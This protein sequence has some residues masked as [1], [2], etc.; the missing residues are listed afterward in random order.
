MCIYHS[1]NLREDALFDTKIPKVEDAGSITG[2]N[3]LYASSATDMTGLTPSIAHNEHEAQ[4]YE[5][6]YPYLPP[7]TD[8]ADGI[9]AEYRTEVT[10][11]FK[12]GEKKPYMD[13]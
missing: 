11:Q 1:R 6:L 10:S 12:H 3:Y 7:A 5:E 13:E 2:Y 4:N 8:P 9:R